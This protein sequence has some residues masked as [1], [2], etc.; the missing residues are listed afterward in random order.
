M[1]KHILKGSRCYIGGPID[2][3]DNSHDWRSPVKDFLRKRFGVKVF[4]PHADPKQSKIPELNKLT[5][6][7]DYEAMRSIVKDFV[8]ADLSIVD[9]SDFVI[10]HVPYKVPTT[11]TT[12]EIINSNNAKKP[13]LLVCPQGKHLIPRWYY[14]FIPLHFMFSS[15]EELYSYLIEVDEG[16]HA[17]DDRWWFLYNYHD[18]DWLR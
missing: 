12:H 6:Q 3:A 7:K 1:A 11:G 18:A 4:D 2:L 8:R 16:M 10:S 5:E 15:W 13:T 17:D 14:G 9:H